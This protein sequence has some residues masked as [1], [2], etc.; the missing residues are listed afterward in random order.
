MT[1]IKVALLSLSASGLIGIAAH[2]G[3]REYAYTPVPGTD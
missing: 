3:Y 1:R 2:E